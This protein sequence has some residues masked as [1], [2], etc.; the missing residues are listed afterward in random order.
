MQKKNYEYK[1]ER[2]REEEKKEEEDV[3]LHI[4]DARKHEPFPSKI[5]TVIFDEKEEPDL[6]S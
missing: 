1:E 5:I 6:P 4:S 3:S 2:R